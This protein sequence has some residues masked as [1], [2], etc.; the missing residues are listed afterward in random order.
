A[1]AAG[2]ACELVAVCD[3]K[4]SRRRGE[5]WDVGGNAVSPDVSG[6]AR[7]LAFDPQRVRAYEDDE[8]LIADPSIDLVSVCTRTDTHVDVAARCL[9]AG[10][11][12]LLEKPVAL[13]SEDIRRLKHVADE[14]G[15]LCMPAMCMRFWPGWDWLKARLND[16][17]FGRCV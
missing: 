16:R 6:S 10:K 9:R 2:F 15:K 12:V 13:K 4:E 8:E 7:K 17:Q 5:L 3:R 11:H 14:R 1:R